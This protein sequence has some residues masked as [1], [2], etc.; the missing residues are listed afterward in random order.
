VDIAHLRDF[1]A[2]VEAGSLSK[3]ATRL[4]VSQ[5]GLSQRMV[6]LEAHL[7]VRLLVRGPRG[8]LPTQ[9]GTVLYRDAQQL[10]RQF[11]RLSQDVADGRHHLHGPV[12]AGLPTTVATPLAP[13]L[14]S[15]T[16]EKHPGIH[17]QLFESMSGYLSELMLAGRLDLAAV[18]REDAAPREAEVPLYSEELYLIGRPGRAPHSADE[19]PLS[20]LRTVPL[21]TPGDRSNLRA[22]ID[23]AFANQG[24]VPR[25]V[26]DVESLGTMIRIA[27]SGEACTILPLSVV[28]G[29]RDRRDL[30]VRRIVDP[31]L[32]RHVAIRTGTD[33]YQPRDAVVAVLE[34]ISEVTKRLADEG[35]WPG[36]TRRPV[37]RAFARPS[38]PPLNLGPAVHR[39]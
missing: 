24:L 21:V 5:P 37:P 25:I 10:V 39:R 6:Q 19:V 4:H 17:L 33:A 31:V 38:G 7:A 32:R 30:D 36:I 23:R 29:H 11:D 34:G 16:K 8:V 15:W 3:A 12:A 9:A 22:L 27:E 2:V 18:F 20:D 14:F 26:A 1:I 13:A 28:T 35:R